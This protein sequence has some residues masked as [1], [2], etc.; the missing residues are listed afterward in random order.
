VNKS[1]PKPFQKTSTEELAVN[2]EFLKNLIE[3]Q[4]LSN[5]PSRK[6]RNRR[7][8]L[9]QAQNEQGSMEMWG[10]T[11]RVLITRRERQVIQLKFFDRVWEN[12]FS[13]KF[14]QLPSPPFLPLF[15][16]VIFV[17]VW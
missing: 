7:S 12:F 5:N 9:Q 10:A 3:E 15:C 13:K 17:A 1:F 11:R 2:G 6:G 8:S 16:F 4:S 14:S